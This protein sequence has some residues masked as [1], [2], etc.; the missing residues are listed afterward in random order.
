MYASA[1]PL[2]KRHRLESPLLRLLQHQRPPRARQLA[3]EKTQKGEKRRHGRRQRDASSSRRR[4]H[5]VEEEAH[6]QRRT[7]ATAEA[8]ARGQEIASLR[9]AKRG[10]HCQAAKPVQACPSPLR[11]LLAAVPPA[12]VPPASFMKTHVPCEYGEHEPSQLATSPG[13]LGAHSVRWLTRPP[14]PSF[15]PRPPGSSR[16]TS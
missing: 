16:R 14:S 12:W 9:P 8:G 15:P 4:S 1:F 6:T 5:S 2:I 10:Q 3:V 11:A 7:P 13:S